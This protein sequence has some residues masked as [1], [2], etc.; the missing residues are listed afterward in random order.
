VEERP[1]VV[2]GAAPARSPEGGGSSGVVPG[3]T[4]AL[5]RPPPWAPPLGHDHVVLSL[6]DLLTPWS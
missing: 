4:A 3:V 6:S 2:G 1:R 5:A